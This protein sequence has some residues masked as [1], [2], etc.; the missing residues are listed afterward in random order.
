MTLFYEV[1]CYGMVAV[2]GSISLT[3]RNWAFNGFLLVYAAAYL[4]MKVFGQDLLDRSGLLANFH[5]LTLPFVIGMIF[6]RFRRFLPLNI[7]CVRHRM[8]CTRAELRELLVQGNFCDLL[9]LFY[10][11]RWLPQVYTAKGL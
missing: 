5:L 4:S 6:Y 9:V 7:N 2:L 3:G 1:T 8:H 11:L 10:F